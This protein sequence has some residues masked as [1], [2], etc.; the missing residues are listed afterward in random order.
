MICRLRLLVLTCAV[1]TV[2]TV[3]AK[4][5]LI[6]VDYVGTVSSVT[7]N[8]SGTFAVGQTLQGSYI[9]ES[10]TPPLA[11]ATVNAATY[12]AI[13]QFDFVVLNG[14]IVY[15][16]STPVVPTGMPEIQI[17]NNV[18]G[19]DRFAAL[20]RASDGL[21]GPDV[22]GLPLVSLGLRSDDFSQAI[23]NTALGLPTGLG[24][25]DFDSNTFFLFFGI[26]LEGLV[27]GSIDSFEFVQVPE[28]STFSLLAMGA[29]VWG[30]CF[31]RSRQK[32]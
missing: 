15:S 16:A 20:S 3:E 31:L 17:D 2:S 25:D 8:L 24:S 32:R 19:H 9:F 27:S 22:N 29:V 7:P 10:T 28:P 18:L 11:G 30:L 1:F 4:A 6:L 23:F 14:G 26:T 5:V 13:T 12:D 21:L